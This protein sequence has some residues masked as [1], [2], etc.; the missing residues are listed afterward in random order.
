M[1][2]KNARAQI[3][4]DEVA[5][6]NVFNTGASDNK[7]KNTSIADRITLDLDSLVQVPPCL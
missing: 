5:S 1:K 3:E 7:A 4:S 6:V 2:R